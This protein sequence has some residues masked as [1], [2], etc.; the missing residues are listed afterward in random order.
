MAILQEGSIPHDGTCFEII[1]GIDAPASA[2]FL[3]ISLQAFN[4]VMSL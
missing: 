2:E 1:E 3:K 4:Y